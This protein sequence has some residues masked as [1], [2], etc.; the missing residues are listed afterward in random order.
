MSELK[1]KTVD[2]KDVSTSNLPEGVLATFD[3][4]ITTGKKDRDGD[5]LEPEGASVDPNMALLWQHD[6]KQPIGK[7]A[8]VTEKSAERVAGRFMLADTELAK[9][10]LVL[11]KLGAL[12]ISHGFR[13]V[14]FEPMKDGYRFSKFEIMEA[15][16]VSVPSNTDAVVT[17]LDEGKF[18]SAI[19]KA[20]AGELAAPSRTEEGDEMNETKTE[21]NET[22]T[23][24]LG[25]REVDLAEIIRR[26]GGKAP[27]A[28]DVFSGVDVKAP[29]ARYDN[30]KTTLAHVKTGKP[31]FDEYNRPVQSVSQREMA[32]A[33]AFL[34]YTAARSGLNCP[35]DEHERE[36]LDELFAEHKWVGLVGREWHKRLDGARVKALLDDAASGGAEVV[37]EF[38]DAAIVQFPLLFGELYPFV[39][40]RDVARGRLVET[41]SIDNPTVTW[42]TAEGT[43]LTAFDTASLVAEINTTIYPVSV[44]LEVGRDFMADAAVDVG[45]A[46]VENIGQRF[47][48]DLDDQIASG[49]G[50][51]QPEGIFTASGVT[52]VGN[53]AGGA[54]AAPTVGDYETLLFGV[55]KQYRRAAFNPCFIANDTS[56][57][58]SRAIAVSG[59]DQRRVFGMDEESYSLLGRPYRIQN[60]IANARQAFGCLKKYRMYRRQAQSVQWTSEGKTLAQA[61]LALLVVRG[62]YGGKIV[63]VNAFCKQTNA[64]A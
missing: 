60:D 15:S 47:S 23:S 6:Y 11:L 8:A 46:L 19:V 53:P 4:T 29:S 10:A 43:T 28:K 25:G 38:F 31:V 64:Q 20:W 2:V 41:A 24:L 45:Q 33:G 26:N 63:D 9:D 51:S 22:G 49:A 62:R 61:N 21:T 48:S 12:R 55:D 14:E 54:G 32:L 50:T 16:L 44:N 17:A 58:R 7:L 5:I 13:P 40:V 56:Y 59:T 3:A 36:L 30:T 37:P 42:G 27:T 18:C 34:K 52:D 35:L 1:R 57:Q 39:D